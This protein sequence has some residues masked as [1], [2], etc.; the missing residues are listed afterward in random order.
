[1]GM[2]D[3]LICKYPLPVDTDLSKE[4]FQTKN[5]PS[6]FLDNYE[7]REDGTLL[8]ETYD[9]ENR[10]NPNAK[11]ITKFIG[12]MTRVNKR[13]EKVSD[14]I[15]EIRFYTTLDGDKTL[16]EFSA[17]FVDGKMKEI[18]LIKEKHE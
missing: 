15:G 12:C 6:Q 17:Y 14:F 9:I 13:W 2:F 5:T 10:S 11:G 3:N 18:H 16:I 7:I 4:I 1:M 8:H